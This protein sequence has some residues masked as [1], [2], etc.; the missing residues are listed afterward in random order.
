MSKKQYV[1]CCISDAD[2]SKE[3]TT[4]NICGNCRVKKPCIMNC[5]E[6]WEIIN[7]KHYIVKAEGK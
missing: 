2:L 5:P 6:K 7:G 3:N 1:N 4:I